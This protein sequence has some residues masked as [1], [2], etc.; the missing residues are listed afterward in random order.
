MAARRNTTEDEPALI[1]ERP[2]P[3]HRPVP[4]PLSR[5]RIVR[6]A[7]DLADTGGLDEVSLRKVAATLDAGPMRLYG[8][9]ATKDELLD[10]MV[11]A[12]YAEITPPEP[13]G[14]DWR[15][16]LRSLAHRT[17]QAALRHEWLADLLGGRPH[18]GPNALAHLEATMSALDAAPGF[19]DIDTVMRAA[20]T[21]HAYTLGA[22]RTEITG[23]RAERASGM[24]EQQWQTASSPYF[25]RMLA[26]G[27]YPTL[28]KIMHEAAHPDT[29]TTFDTGLDCVLDGIATRLG[30]ECR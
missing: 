6:A 16:A 5:A 8:Y 10:L 24:T 1:W 21:V 20:G 18:I 2:E 25:A 27:R 7:I 17:R 23:R 4:S 19:N 22:L 15:T 13:T 29:D 11:D 28:A 30:S 12:V 9:V 14:E 26:T 3:P